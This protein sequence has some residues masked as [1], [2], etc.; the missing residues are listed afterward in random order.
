MTATIKD[1]ARLANVSHTTVSRALNDSPFIHHETKQKILK[2]AEQLSYMPNYSAKSLV[3]S[4]SYNIGLFFTTLSTGTSSGFLHEAL[5]GMNHVVKDKYNLVVKGVDDDPSFRSI[6]KRNFDGIVLM[7][8]S[9]HDDAFIKHVLTQEIPLVVLN[10]DCGRSEVMN[11]LS[12]D[13]KGAR[14]M[15]EYL[16]GL[17][18][19]RIAVI[20]GKEGFKST[21][22]RKNGYLEA[23]ECHG[24]KRLPDYQV[25]GNYEMESGFA[26]MRRLLALACPPTAVFCSNDEMA[27]GAMKAVAERGFR[28]PEDVSVTGFDDN[29]FSGFITPALTTVKRPIEK[30]SAAGAEKL[31]QRL[32]QNES[33][34]ETIYMNTELIVRQSAAPI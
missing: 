7:S 34:A 33:A 17:G 24:V 22:E 5:K 13:R 18:H 25:Q 6:L 11:I 12:D 15:V 4:R 2:I 10:R 32:E 28:V 16:I 29:L 21:D 8:Q 19:R 20:E 23:L 27:V 30:I 31:L 26:A 9:S 3:L 14:M 1:I